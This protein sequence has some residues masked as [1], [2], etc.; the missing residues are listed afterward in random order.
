MDRSLSSG[1]FVMVLMRENRLEKGQGIYGG[2]G[3]VLETQGRH[4]EHELPTVQAFADL[5]QLFAVGRV[6]QPQPHPNYAHLMPR[7]SA[8]NRREFIMLNNT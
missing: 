2:T 7:Q 6:Y 1:P 5:H 8:V 3:G 4:V